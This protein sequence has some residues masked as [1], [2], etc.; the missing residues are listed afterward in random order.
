MATRHHDTKGL[1]VDDSRDDPRL[2]ERQGYDNHVKITPTQLR[3]QVYGEVLMQ[4]QRHPGGAGMQGRNQARQQVGCNGIDDA[5]AQW[6]MQ[7]ILSL[8][9]DLPESSSLLKHPFG[10]HRDLFA[11]RRQTYISG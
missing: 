8:L 3:R 7:G 10:L 9:D 11:N 5:K 4:V 2:D 6:P 1:L